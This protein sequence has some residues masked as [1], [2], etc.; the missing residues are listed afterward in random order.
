[1]QESTAV[2]DGLQAFYDRFSAHDPEAFA[3]GLAA[4]PAVSVIGSGPG[5][6]HDNREAWV[7]AYAAF[8]TTAGLRL[9]GGANPRGWEEGSVGFAVDEPRFV[10][11]DGSFLATRLTGVLHVEDGSWK[12]VHLHFSVGVP[13]EEVIQPPAGTGL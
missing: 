7:A 3:D 10:L 1:M 8:V 13:D 2:R 5:E 11:P 6:G 12:V 4:G 9:E